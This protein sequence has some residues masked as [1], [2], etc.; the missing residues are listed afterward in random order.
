MVLESNLNITKHRYNMLISITWIIMQT[1]N[2]KEKTKTH[3]SIAISGAS[4]GI[5]RALALAFANEAT[6][7]YL[8]G[9]NK[10][11]LEECRQALLAKN[12]DL[13]I[14]YSAFD[15]NDEKACKNWCNEIFK[16]RLDILI[17]NA[18]IA[19]GMQDNADKHIEV[20][21]TNTLGVA[22]LAFYALDYFKLQTPFNTENTNTP[23]QTL[24]LMSS[25]ASLA[26]LPNAPSYSA[27]KYFV[28]I[29]GESLSL[30]TNNINIS[31][32]CPGFIRT[33]LTESISP[34]I[35]QMQ[36]EVAARKIYNAIKKGKRLYIFPFWLSMLARIYALLPFKLQRMLASLLNSMGHL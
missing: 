6:L 35:P 9:R 30:S 21:Q 36:L 31:V 23:R 10:Y 17:L 14:L 22:N 27:S 2:T 18:G 34:Y 3:Y 16:N 28:R 25:I 8:A 11:R 20:S 4:S 15:I 33:K 12:K 24:V 26:P 7:I 5:G 19:T 13:E 32:I 1:T 29:L